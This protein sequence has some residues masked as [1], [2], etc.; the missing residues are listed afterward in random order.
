MIQRIEVRSE[1]KPDYDIEG[2]LAPW[3]LLPGTSTELAVWE[4][5]V[6]VRKA[7]ISTYITWRQVK[8]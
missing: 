3:Q 5:N 4:G 2:Q 7:L 8:E 1:Q 6:V